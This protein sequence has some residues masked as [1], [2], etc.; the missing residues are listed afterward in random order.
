VNPARGAASSVLAGSLLETGNRGR[1]GS[2]K[3]ADALY[4]ERS[5]KEK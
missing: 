4:A 2:P 3:M 5:T 1:E